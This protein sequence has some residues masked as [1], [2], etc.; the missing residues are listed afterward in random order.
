MESPKTVAEDL[1]PAEPFIGDRGYEFVPAADVIGGEHPEV[2]ADLRA[3]VKRFQAPPDAD[4]SWINVYRVKRAP[5]S[6]KARMAFLERIGAEDPPDEAMLKARYGGGEYILRLEWQSGRNQKGL[7]TSP[8]FID[9]W[10]PS[11][12]PAASSS[13]APAPAAVPVSSAVD[14][15]EMESRMWDRME[16]LVAMIGR[17]NP[18]PPPP[19][20]SA[21]AIVEEA[22][23]TA[24]RI[25]EDASKQVAAMHKEMRM[26]TLE[27]IHPDDD[28]DDDPETPAPAPVDPL[29]FVPE[30]IRP[31]F[32]MIE[33]GFK[34]L[35]AGNA[36]DTAMVKGMLTTSEDFQ[37]VLGDQKAVA[38]LTHA[39]SLLHGEEK[40]NRAWALL[41]EPES[42][43]RT[44]RERVARAA[45]KAAGKVSQAKA[46]AKGK[47]KRA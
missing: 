9:E 34:K 25:L 30:F 46:K 12:A 33:A 11:K 47:G 16:R 24:N 7:Q 27:A 37:K 14:P 13:S 20:P 10:E 44:V 19:S 32:P 40:V 42:E 1:R 43:K 17:A 35:L 15:L 4:A 6:Q 45:G 41:N 21:T 38:G 26:M 18:P 5:G 31:Y 29:G 2:P 22:Q 39:L 23:K 8:I 36:T 28:E 3:F